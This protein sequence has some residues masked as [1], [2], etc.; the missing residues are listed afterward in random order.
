MNVLRIE[1]TR[2]VEN[3]TFAQ[4]NTPTLNYRARDVVLEVPLLDGDRNA[5]SV[6]PNLT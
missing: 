1:A 2:E 5:W 6:H 4:G 3:V